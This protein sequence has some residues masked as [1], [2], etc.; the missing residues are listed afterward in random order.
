MS[1]RG[2]IGLLGI[3]AAIVLLS[4]GRTTLAAD[5]SIP[6]P[7]PALEPVP[8]PMLD[9]AHFP[10]PATWPALRHEKPLRLL[11]LLGKNASCAGYYRIA[12]RMHATVDFRFIGGGDDRY[13]V[14]DQW[15]EPKDKP[16]VEELKTY[17]RQVVLDSLSYAA[18]QRPWDVIFC[19]SVDWKDVELQRKLQAFAADGG[20]L[21]AWGGASP[22]DD[23]PLGTLWPAK[24]TKGKSW[25]DGGGQRGDNPEL[26]GLPWQH[27]SGHVYI[28]IPQAAPGA[29]ELSKGGAGYVFKR[30]AG[31]GC[32][33][34]F[35]LS[36]VISRTHDP[37]AKFGRLLDHDEI[38]LRLWD[39]VLHEVVRGQQAFPAYSDLRPGAAE[40]SPGAEYVLPGRIVNRSVAGPM[41]WTVHVTSPAGKVLHTQQ[42]ELNVAAGQTQPLVVRVKIAP[43]WSAGMYPVYLTVAHSKAKQQLHQSMQWI[44]VAGSLKLNLVSAKLGYKLGDTAAF[45]LTAS[46]RSPWEGQIALA[47]YDFRGRVLGLSTRDVNLTDQPQEIRFEHVMADHGVRVDTLLAQ[48]AAIQKGVEFGRAEAKF[49]KYE[50]WDM[51][52]EYQWSTWAGIACAAPSLVPMSMGLMAHAGMNSLGYPG[53]S[54]LWYAAERWSWRYYN[55]GVGMNT[56]SPVIEYENDQEIEA[57]LT[58]EADRS[59]KNPGLTSAAFVIASIGEEA[60]YKVGWGKTYYWDTP[61]APDKACRALQWYLKTK[62]PSLEQ[63]NQVWHTR[64]SAWDQIKLTKEF[65]GRAAAP[66]ADGWAHPKEITPDA[67]TQATSLAPYADTQAFYAW[68]YDKII[69]IAKRLYREKINPV[70]RLI[71]SAPSSAT[72]NSRECDIKLMGPGCWNESQN[73][74]LAAGDEP[75]FGLIWGH[76]DWMVQT[77]NMLWGWLLNGSGHNN[78]WVDIPLM[79]NNDMTHTRA[80]FAMRRFIRNFAG[81]ERIILDSR[82]ID[83][84]VGLLPVEG[85]PDDRMLGDMNSSLAVA[86]NQSGFSYLPAD[87]KDLSKYKILFAPG[88]QMLSQEMAAR[89]DQ[90]VRNGG[91]LVIFPRFGSQNELGAPVSVPPGQG[92]SEMWGLKTERTAGPAANN[93][94]ITASLEALDKSLAGAVISSYKSY[95]AKVN[96]TGWTQLGAYDDGVPLVLTRLLGRGRV[97]FVNAV[98]FSHHYIQHVTPTDAPRQGFCRLVEWLCTSAGASRD[99]RID[100]PLD[101]TLHMAVREFR[102]ETGHIRYAIVRTNGEVPW[103]HGTFNWLGASTACYDVLDGEPGKPAALLGKSIGLHLQPGHGKLLAFVSSPIGQIDLQVRPAQLVAGQPVELTATITGQDGQTIPG[104]FPFELRAYDPA[105]R[106]IPGLSRSFSRQSGKT[107]TLNTALSDPAGSCTL[108]LTDA[109]SGLSGKASISISAPPA[110]AGAPAFNSYGWPSELPEPTTLTSEQFIGHLR[111]LGQVYMKDHSADAWRTKQALGY[112][113]CYFPGTRHDVIRPLLDVDWRTYAA[114]ITSALNDGATFVL[115]G[116]DLGIHPGS[117]LAVYPHRD[118]H[119]V[120]AL[121]QAL[122]GAKWYVGTPDGDTVIASLGRGHLVLS[123]ESVDAAGNT[124]P[125]ISRWQQRWLKQLLS[126][127]SPL[128]TEGRLSISPPDEQKLLRWW[129][130]LEP[131][132]T[133]PRTVSWLAGNQAEATLN[134][135]PAKRLSSVFSFTLPPNG[136]VTKLTF[137]ISSP[138]GG[139]VQFDIGCDGVP[140]VAITLKPGE[141]VLPPDWSKAANDY[142]QSCQRPGA[143]LYRDENGRRIIPVRLSSDAKGTVTISEVQA[144]VQ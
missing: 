23:T 108:V 63:L 72:F 21:V 82:R 87:D 109:I 67:G 9:I 33:L 97:T 51:R 103:T 18:G 120:Q 88:L 127:G 61:V 40:A 102:D 35:T 11:A 71:S 53:R 32:I 136:Q 46:S 114:A 95:R 130:G 7:G 29:E 60:G 13:H 14:N 96:H 128:T 22:A 134:V 76:F 98:Y 89:L 75:G 15:I 131:L 110:M 34:Y 47:V 116:E 121:V 57:W 6:Y 42:E 12:Q 92:L 94:Q 118:A 100:G 143:T 5:P 73:H 91:T 65:S 48:A 119:Q 107:Y 66:G 78:Y 113:Y 68:Y 90:Y 79:F 106:E 144:T 112:F 54:E 141:R 56:W 24:P 135:D 37:F 26:A 52:N 138:E 27:V 74:S 69:A 28:P 99:F 105:G 44:P 55:E 45:T 64:F 62:Y 139:Q 123:R 122:G 30:R 25:S 125:E 86:C 126:A 83:S 1:A 111:Q 58:K 140:D 4:M 59:A 31:E 41:T 142:L 101:E 70:S 81:H 80:S 124:N 115:T 49:Y 17:A 84:G 129:V 133:E 43:E 16:S 117:G 137:A 19:G 3:A 8:G 38:L 10:A 77:D 20:V 39:Q 93:Q 50:L 132:T 2:L 36:D 85:K 104:S